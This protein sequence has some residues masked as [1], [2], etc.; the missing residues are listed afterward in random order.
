MVLAPM[1]LGDFR[2]RLHVTGTVRTTGGLECPVNIEISYA[3]Y[4]PGEL[5]VHVVCPAP[6]W[7]QLGLV[8]EKRQ[9]GLEVSGEDERGQTLRLQDARLKSHRGSR[10]EFDCTGFT[11]GFESAVD[12]DSGEYSAQVRIPYTDLVATWST[13][14]M[15]YLGTIQSKRKYNE[16]IRWSSPLGE[17]LMADFYHF[18][19][20]PLRGQGVLSRV[21]VAELRHEGKVH[22][23]FDPRLLVD[24]VEE[25]IEEPLY[26]LSFLSRTP[27]FWYEI[28]TTLRIEGSD[29]A[30][31][32]EYVRRR[33]MPSENTEHAW[34]LAD[35][36]HLAGD[37]FEQLLGRLRASSVKK[38]LLRA[39]IY[40]V[41]SH[42]ERS[43]ETNLSMIYLA[44]ESL[45]NAHGV[46]GERA[47]FERGLQTLLKNADIDH[48]QLW[49]AHIKPSKGVQE[50]AER[51]RKFIHEACAEDPGMLDKDCGRLQLI[52]ERSIL[53][54]LGCG[55]EWIDRDAYDTRWLA[56]GA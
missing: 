21:K 23:R 29:G 35:R 45:F 50:L 44:A 48:R 20:A 46:Q 53:A 2:E 40:C 12:F 27:L 11:F 24:K 25:A 54:A 52:A 51:R 33:E 19:Q 37:A 28:R 32:R 42:R 56:S 10:A 18:E 41:G 5:E 39:M 4:V 1:K 17:F 16:G 43:L 49:P 34:A 55:P 22:S 9:E 14:G 47:K 30:K 3:K 13:E 8:L 15:S 36:W 7:R 38:W 26:L 6:E 31:W